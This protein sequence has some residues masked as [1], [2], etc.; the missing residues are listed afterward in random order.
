M[1]S[2]SLTALLRQSL[3]SGMPLSTTNR[4]KLILILQKQ[5]TISLISEQIKFISSDSIFGGL[6]VVLVVKCTTGGNVK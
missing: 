2:H 6:L 3:S 1:S 5:T 4:K